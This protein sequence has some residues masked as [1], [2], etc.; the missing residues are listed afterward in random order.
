MSM[1]EINTTLDQ[2]ARLSSSELSSDIGERYAD[3]LA[4]ILPFDRHMSYSR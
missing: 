1:T 3:V 4:A 2:I